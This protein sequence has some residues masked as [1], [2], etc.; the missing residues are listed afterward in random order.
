MQLYYVPVYGNIVSENVCIIN[1][2]I[3]LSIKIYIC[4]HLNYVQT[5]YV[6]ITTYEWKHSFQKRLY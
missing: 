4:K 2:Q 1:I 3:I 5:Y 6:H